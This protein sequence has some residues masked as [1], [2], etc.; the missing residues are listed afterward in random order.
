MNKSVLQKAVLAGLRASYIEYISALKK[1]I[2]WAKLSFAQT[3]A[4]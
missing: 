3:C 2:A 1:N 4:I